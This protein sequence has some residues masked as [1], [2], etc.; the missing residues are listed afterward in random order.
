MQT[1]SVVNSMLNKRRATTCYFKQS[2]DSNVTV[3]E[4]GLS[5]GVKQHDTA[6]VIHAELA[7]ELA[8]R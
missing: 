6:R 8:C 1:S 4:F 7:T 5:K 2:S 3:R